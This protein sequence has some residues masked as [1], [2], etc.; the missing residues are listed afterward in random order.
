MTNKKIKGKVIS[1]KRIT[2]ARAIVLLA[3]TLL[4]TRLFYVMIVKNGSLDALATEQWTSDVKINA[5]RGRI[6]DRNEKELAVSADV[7]RADLDLKTLREDMEKEKLTMEQLSKD[8]SH[9]I[10]MEEKTVYD[11]LTKPDGNGNPKN[12]AVLKR[13]IEKSEVD[14]IKSYCKEKN[15]RG[16][17]IYP[18]TKR[19]YPNNNFASHLLGHTNSDGEGL[20][21]IELYYDRYLAGI[22][23]FRMSQIDQ[24]GEDLPFEELKVTSPVDGRDVV[25]TIDETIQFYA[26]KRASEALK[27]NKAKAVSIMVMDPNNGEILAMAN[28]PDYDPNNPWPKDKNDNDIQKLW[29]NR[30][31]NDAYEPGSIFKIVT[32]TAAIEEGVVKPG[33]T[34]YCGGY[35]TKGGRKI[36]CWDRDGHGSLNFQQMLKESCN[37]GTMILG[38][39]IGKEKLNEYIEKFGFGEKTGI[40]LPGEA[41]GIIK[42]TKDISEVDLATISFG[43]TNTTTAIQY[44]R[45][46]NAIANGGKLITPHVMKEVIHYNENNERI[47]DDTFKNYNEKQQLNKDTMD[48]LKD[49]LVVKE[50]KDESIKG[51]TISG[52]TGTAEKMDPIKGGYA[53]GKYISSFA[54]MAPVDNPKYTVFVSIDEPNGSAYFASQIA[55][56]VA[57]KLF[58]DIFRYNP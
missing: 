13:R 10:A 23:G 16:I 53:E 1:K 31:V 4:I 45:A 51:Y 18:D 25:L 58:E 42:P 6:L 38:E 2:I 26:E 11:I 50:K 32:A 15:I 30:L 9:I 36:H 49:I 20:T 17:V 7:Y 3:F 57:K 54:G 40:D 34:F 33:E 8:I 41:I 52:K 5:K 29:R 43:Q 27:E 21:G 55:E 19:Y 39:R 56:P 14:G 46:L 48:I 44:M 22:P 24:S 28:K 47:V 37:V 35:L 12:F